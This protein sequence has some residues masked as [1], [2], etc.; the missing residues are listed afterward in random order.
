MGV[1]KGFFGRFWTFF[2][3]ERGGWGGT[4]RIT[5]RMWGGAAAFA[6]RRRPGYGRKAGVAKRRQDAGKRR[7]PPRVAQIRPQGLSGGD[8]RIL[9][10]RVKMRTASWMQPRETWRAL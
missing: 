3:G 8:W 5:S 1:F 4:R 9:S 2:R 7:G 6:P 10:F